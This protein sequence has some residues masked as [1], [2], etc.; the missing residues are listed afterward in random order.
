[1]APL[2]TLLGA[3]KAAGA[4]AVTQFIENIAGPRPIRERRH[5]QDRLALLAPK[6]EYSVVPRARAHGL[7]EVWLAEAL[8]AT[9]RIEEG[10]AVLDAAERGA[11]ERGERGTLAHCWK[12]RAQLAQ[13]A[14]DLV[15]AEIHYR[16][17]LAA[18][19]TALDGAGLRGVRGGSRRAR[20]PAGRIFS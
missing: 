7:A 17:S 19:P 20:R 2:E 3:V 13:A 10:M 5:R 11:L 14:G 9:R 4:L 1:M 16:R 6:K 12:A 18:G 8:G 15:E